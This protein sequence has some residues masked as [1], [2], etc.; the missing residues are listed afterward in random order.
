MKYFICACLFLIHARAYAVTPQGFNGTCGGLTGTPN[1]SVGTLT[2]SGQS[3]LGSSLR[4]SS[5]N[6]LLT[7]SWGM[8]VTTGDSTHPFHIDSSALV[9]GS[10]PGGG[11]Y[12]VGSVYASGMVQAASHNTVASTVS[13]TN[14]SATTLFSVSSATGM[15]ML[16]AYIAGTGNA[17]AYVANAIISVESGSARIM[18]QTSGSLL[19]ISLSTTNVQ[20][21]QTTGST[22]TISYSYLKMI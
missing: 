22:Q 19:S 8:G 1:I 12:G 9:V 10:A 4:F 16:M 7:E 2:T 13:A 5:G 3:V 18:Q 21:T 20:A 15:Y 14:G 11:T 17:S 6:S